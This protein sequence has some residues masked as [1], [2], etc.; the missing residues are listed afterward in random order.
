MLFP[1][2]AMGLEATYQ[3]KFIG[4]FSADVFPGDNFPSNPHFS[5]V[6]VVSHNKDY[7]LFKKGGLATAGVQDVA[8]TGNP[9]ELTKELNAA[10]MVNSVLAFTRTGPVDGD[11]VV[12][13]TI[14]VKADAPYLSV[15]S[16]IAPSPDW[17]VGLSSVKLLR[18]G[19]FIKRAYAPLYAIDGGTDSGL[20]YTSRNEVTDPQG[21][22]SRLKYI[23]GKK[24]KKPHAF[25]LIQKIN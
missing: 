1:T 20:D 4:N 25:I 21:V 12:S 10:Q 11:A 9:S 19:R 13:V 15:L 6:N 5:P 17:V 14:K 8:E 2:F 24:V 3:V 7:T 18:K 16:M 23:D 22:I